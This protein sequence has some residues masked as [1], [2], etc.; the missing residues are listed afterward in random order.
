MAFLYNLNKKLR[1]LS[2]VEDQGQ[3]DCILILTYD[4]QFQSLQIMVMTHTHAKD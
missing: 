1:K 3:T 2:S 4:V